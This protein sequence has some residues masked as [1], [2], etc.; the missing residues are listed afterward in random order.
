MAPCQW[1]EIQSKITPVKTKFLFGFIRI[2][3]HYIK[4]SGKRNYDFMLGMVGMAPANLPTRNIVGAKSPFYFKGKMLM[5]LK[6]GKISTGIVYPGKMKNSG[7]GK[8]I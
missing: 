8:I 7:F 6:E 2:F 1:R 4:A 5:I 3:N